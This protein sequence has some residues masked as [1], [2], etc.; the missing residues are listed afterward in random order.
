M[1]GS[2]GFEEDI[3]SIVTDT[4][5]LCMA[6]IPRGSFDLWNWD[7]VRSRAPLILRHLR[8]EDGLMRMPPTGWPEEKIAR[9]EAWLRE[10]LPKHRGGVYADFFRAIDAQTEYF[11]VYGTREGLDDMRP[12]YGT[13]FGSLLRQGP[14]KDYVRIVPSTE[15]LRK[16]KRLLWDRVLQAIADPVVLNGLLRIDAWLCG[17]VEHHF[18]RDD[19]L[20]TQA[21]FD[22]F[23]RFG[24]DALPLDSDREQRVRALGNPGDYRLVDDYAR[25][26]RMDTREMWFNWFGHMQCVFAALA[27]GDD[28]RGPVRSALLAAIFVGQTFDTAYRQGSNGLTRPAYAGAGGS[29]S[30][31]AT[32]E[33]LRDDPESAMEEMEQLYLIWSGLVPPA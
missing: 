13:F 19:A 5:H 17:L 15:L 3:R 33:V 1:L 16:R 22:A 2:V 27:G 28:P 20:D 14:W 7:Q 6:S 29:A 30:I 24:G 31:L 18:R 26:H 9:F 23:S 32:A 8:A 10:G 4:E 25:F 12:A 11:D 21:L